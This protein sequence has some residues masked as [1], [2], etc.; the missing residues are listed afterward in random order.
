MNFGRLLRSSA[1]PLGELRE[2]RTARAEAAR[3]RT[4]EDAIRQQQAEDREYELARRPMLDEL[5]K[6]QVGE[7]NRRNTADVAKPP[8][9]QKLYDPE[10]GVVVDELT[11]TATPVQGL[12]PKPAR[13]LSPAQQGVKEQREFQRS[14]S[15]GH[16]YKQNPTVKGAYS[17]AQV[18]SGL[19]AGLSGDTPMDDLSVIYETVKLFDPNSVVREGEIKLFQSAASLPLQLRL[20]VDRWNSGKL[21]TPGMRAHIAMLLDRKM[22]ESQR[23]IAPVQSEFGQQAR[24]YGVEADSAFIAPDPFKGI[25]RD[26]RSELPHQDY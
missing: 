10:R 21:L 26:R 11:S 12:P 8:T 23:A 18:V 16:D 1:Q 25:Q 3:K 19:K 20:M 14:Q 4:L 17:V 24:R 6:A 15:L 7:I 2:R 22:G 9:P 13:D 5:L